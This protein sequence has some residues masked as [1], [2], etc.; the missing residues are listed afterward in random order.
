MLRSMPTGPAGPR[1]VE[2]PFGNKIQKTCFSGTIFGF[3]EM[4]ASE[5]FGMGR[6]I[7]FLFF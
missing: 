2:G 7:W 6:F 3:Y 4:D 1:T 5:I